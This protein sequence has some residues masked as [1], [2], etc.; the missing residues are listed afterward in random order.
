MK[1]ELENQEWVSP[2]LNTTAD[3]S[4]YL[5]VLDLAKW[6]EAL[7]KETILAPSSR[8]MIWQPARLNGKTSVPYGFGWFLNE[9][10]GRRLLEHGGSWQ[11]FRAHIARYIDD[12]LTVIV[13]ANLAQANVGRIAHEVAGLYDEDLER[14]KHEAVTVAPEILER[15]TGRYA[16]TPKTRVTIG[17][18]GDR[19]TAGFEDSES[20]ELLPE[21]ETTFFNDEQELEVVFV[22]G[23][24]GRPTALLWRDV[25]EIEAPRL[26]P[27]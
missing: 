12:H 23:E 1:D 3:G 21:S 8:G 10:R 27:P 22:L 16:L 19:L 17:R 6:D 25:V 18:Q 26:E 2:S 14:V 15:Y 13:L 9:I 24:H 4:L 7:A 20:F 5:T 11:G